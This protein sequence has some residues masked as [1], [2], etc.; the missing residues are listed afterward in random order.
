MVGELSCEET[1]ELLRRYEVLKKQCASMHR[2]IM[3][4]DGSGSVSWMVLL[5]TGVGGEHTR[6]HLDFTFRVDSTCGASWAGNSC[7]DIKEGELPP[8]LQAARE[9]LV[10]ALRR[11][12]SGEAPWP[13]I[14]GLEGEFHCDDKI[15]MW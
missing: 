4:S 3:L 12:H 1:E 13:E 5:R 14:L 2:R 8:H 10:D 11:W 7:K 15:C 9:R 6:R